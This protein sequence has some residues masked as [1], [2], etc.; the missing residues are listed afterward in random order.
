MST[1]NVTT[2]MTTVD[3][4]C[5]VVPLLSNDLSEMRLDEKASVKIPDD[6]VE[7]AK[8]DPEL[9]KLR[10]I[11]Q[12]LPYPIDSNVSMQ[13]NLDLIL[14]RIVQC[15]KARDFDRGLLEWD[16]CLH[17]WLYLKY[18]IPKPK[19]VALIKLYYDVVT[20][21]CM[22]DYVT[23][24]I[25]FTLEILTK[26]KKKIS[27]SDMRLPWKPIY[28]ILSKNLFLPR[29]VYTINC[30]PAAMCKLVRSARRFFHPA[31]INEMLETILPFMNGTNIDV[32]PIF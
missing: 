14:M 19:R 9:E 32:S 3:W 5:D 6:I 26:S 16:V 31:A 21:P 4:D 13:E 15:V 29:R 7:G 23:N 22:P 12:G 18:P 1:D 25:M 20:Q 10:I 2:Q 28:E 8:T 27:L 30:L 24:S 11:A 17:R